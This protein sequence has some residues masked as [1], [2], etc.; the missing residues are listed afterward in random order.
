MAPQPNSAVCYSEHGDF[1]IAVTTP[2]GA[3]ERRR[4]AA[5]R[6]YS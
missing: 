6:R 3:H 1:E 2:E 4:L 5:A